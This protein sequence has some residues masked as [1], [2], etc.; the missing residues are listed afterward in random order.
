MNTVTES[1]LFSELY[2]QLDKSEKDWIGKV[3]AQLKDNLSVGKPLIFDWLREKKFG[4][5]RLFFLV[6]EKLGK[7]MLFSFSTKKEQQ[8]IINH[9]IQNKEEYLR[10]LNEIT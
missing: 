7:A 6:N 8:T 5:K 9:V 2:Y 10:M 3:I 4:N 1:E